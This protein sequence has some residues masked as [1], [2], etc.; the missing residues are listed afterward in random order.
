MRTN[1][2]QTVTYSGAH[3]AHTSSEGTSDML[4]SLRVRRDR[5]W[6]SHRKASALPTRRYADTRTHPHAARTANPQ[7]VGKLQ[8]L[9]VRASPS[10]RPACPVLRQSGC[11]SC[12]AG[13]RSQGERFRQRD[14]ALGL[15]STK[16]CRMITAMVEY[17]SHKNRP[18][19]TAARREPS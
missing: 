2:I 3:S 8:T 10:Y 9:H 12:Q 19:K 1:S 14:R 15:S 7:S 13:R 11:R 17:I 16:T 5:V 4:S 18:A 6:T